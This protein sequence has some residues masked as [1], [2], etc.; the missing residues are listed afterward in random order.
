MPPLPNVLTVTLPLMRVDEA[1]VA[2]AADDLAA[3][4]SPT[5]RGR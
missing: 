5:C 3:R 4:A 1:E 2:A